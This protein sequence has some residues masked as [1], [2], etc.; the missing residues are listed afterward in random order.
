MER[1]N[2]IKMIVDRH[3]W[4]SID[5][6]LSMM[7]YRSYSIDHVLSIML[8]STHRTCGDSWKE[9]REVTLYMIK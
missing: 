2:E 3:W 9:L 6:V 1:T 8:C 4:C 7:F 5:D